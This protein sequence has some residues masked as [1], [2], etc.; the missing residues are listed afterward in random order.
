MLLYILAIITGFTLLIFSADQF[1]NSS[2]KIANL[3]KIPPLVIGLVVLGFGTSAPEIIVS[4]LAA[5]DGNPSLGVGNAIGSN[6]TNIALILGVTALI[7][8]IVVADNILKKEWVV[9]LFATLIAWL[10]LFDGYLSTMDGLILLLLLVVM[11]FFLIM[12]SKKNHQVTEIEKEA[13]IAVN[14]KDKLKIWGYLLG[15][16]LLLLGSAQLSVWGAIGIAETLGIS[17]L[18]IGLT[19]VALGTSLPELA[20]SISAVLKNQ[21]DLIIGNVIGSN[22]FNTLAVLAMPGIIAPHYLS[23]FINTREFPI[24]FIL[25]ITLFIVSY[26]FNKNHSINRLEGGILV[27]IY[28][29]YMSILF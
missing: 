26:S 20:V 6:I 13:V 5:F 29:A 16:L 12:Q 22:L 19:I 8:P 4:S 7:K 15:S 14:P 2:A 18:V 9:L 25:T 27:A 23:S 28:I 3:W 10:L 11:L 21:N 1:T 17:K 24:L